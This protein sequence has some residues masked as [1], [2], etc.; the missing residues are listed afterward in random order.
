MVFLYPFAP[1]EK[2]AKEA[3]A[4]NRINETTMNPLPDFF[5]EI[6][7]VKASALIEIKRQNVRCF[8]KS[9]LSDAP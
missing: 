1:P 8:I 9:R 4:M 3:Q 6:I 5:R 2:C 7:S